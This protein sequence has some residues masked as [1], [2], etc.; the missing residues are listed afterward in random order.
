MKWT[1]RDWKLLP[2]KGNN[3]QEGNRLLK[4]R[5][6]LPHLCFS[7]F[8]LEGCPFKVSLVSFK[9]NSVIL[10]LWIHQI[11]LVYMKITWILLTRILQEF[12]AWVSLSLMHVT[13]KYHVSFSNKRTKV[14]HLG[15]VAYMWSFLVIQN[16]SGNF[17]WESIANWNRTIFSSFSRVYCTIPG[18]EYNHEKYFHI[19]WTIQFY[20]YFHICVPFSTFQYK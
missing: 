5:M 12:L 10:T 1:P 2:P 14:V 17:Y 7:P 6:K 9:G 4:P 19:F 16:S 15:V 13:F 3:Q 20:E 11:F 8:V 18:F